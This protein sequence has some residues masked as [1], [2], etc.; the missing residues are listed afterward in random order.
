MIEKA[1]LLHHQQVIEAADAVVE[2]PD[3]LRDLIGRAI[4]HH[5]LLAL[6]LE[7]L[8][9]HGV[10]AAGKCALQ[11]LDVE[12]DRHIA[13]RIAEL[14]LGLGGHVPDEL[15]RAGLGVVLRV[16]GDRPAA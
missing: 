1:R 3:L 13:G 10:G 7:S 2:A 11:R 12:L 6:K 8:R 14:R 15:A 4:H 16:A 5:A 9:P